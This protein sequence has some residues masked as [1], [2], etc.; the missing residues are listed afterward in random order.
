MSIANRYLDGSVS[1]VRSDF[2]LCLALT[3]RGWV[4]V[5]TVAGCPESLVTDDRRVVYTS[6]VRRFVPLPTVEELQGRLGYVNLQAMDRA[7]EAIAREG[8][9]KWEVLL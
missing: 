2:S 3:G 9:I 5:R 1:Y 6:E 7:H 8:G 4:R